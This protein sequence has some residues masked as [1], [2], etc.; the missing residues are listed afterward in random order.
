MLTYR[1]LGGGLLY[2]LPMAGV[3]WLL[4]TIDGPW[5]QPHPAG[6]AMANAWLLPLALCAFLTVLLTHAVALNLPREETA[7]EF[8]A[9]YSNAMQI[10]LCIGAF[11]FWIATL[12]EV[13]RLAMALAIGVGVLAYHATSI[14]KAR[15]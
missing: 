7:S 3:E 5:W 4:F 1:Q 12:W 15:A 9:G 13:L 14:M 6:E 11:A 10:A 8:W 2:A